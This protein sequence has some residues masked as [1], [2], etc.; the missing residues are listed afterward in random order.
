MPKPRSRY[1]YCGVCR[2]HYEDYK[3]HVESSTHLAHLHRSFYQNLII[4]LCL[5]VQREA[6]KSSVNEE[7]LNSQS[8]EGSLTKGLSEATMDTPSK[9]TIS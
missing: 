9:T 4:H 5:K 7:C 1:K 3:E 2:G 8:E 6:D